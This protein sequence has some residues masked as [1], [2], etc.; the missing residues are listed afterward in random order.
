MEYSL[1]LTVVHDNIEYIGIYTGEF[2]INVYF[3][4]KM[5]YNTTYPHKLTTAYFDRIFLKKF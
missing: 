1:D 4:T 5:L 3:Y 2:Q